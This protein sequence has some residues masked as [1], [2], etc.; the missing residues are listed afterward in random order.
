MSTLLIRYRSW[1]ERRNYASRTIISYLRQIRALS[2]Y[3]GRCPTQLSDEQL[4]SYW[5]YL[6]VDRGLSQS[7]LSACYSS[8]KLLWEKVLKRSWPAVD[9]PRSRRSK[10]VPEVL[11]RQEVQLLLGGIRNV[12]HRVLLST[13]YSSGL[14]LSEVVGLRLEAIDSKRMLIHVRQG[15]GAKDRST[16]LS[17]TLL[18]ALR[19]YYRL[20]RP[21]F[22]LFEGRVVG[23][24]YSVRSVQQV[25]K[26]ALKR[27]GITRQASVHTLRHS[28]A[29]HLIEGGLDIV[30]LQHLLG[31][32]EVST[33]SRYI[34]VANRYERVEDLLS[35]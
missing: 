22:F 7:S 3:Y 21:K 28:F 11:S 5:D 31:H 27:S 17:I 33:T 26:K 2:D 4:I 30:S 24:P 20:Y 23:Q 15:K 29:T 9:L 14:R 16:I 6:R 1:L 19:S 10:Q 25:F 34:H 12:K 8:C 18:E 13:I 35:D 32:R